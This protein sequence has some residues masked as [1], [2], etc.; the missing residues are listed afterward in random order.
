VLLVSAAVSPLIW[1]GYIGH[2]NGLMFLVAGAL[3]CPLSVV[4][5]VLDD[6]L[7]D[8][9]AFYMTGWPYFRTLGELGAAA[10]LNIYLIRICQSGGNSERR[11][12]NGVCRS[13]ITQ[14]RWRV[15]LG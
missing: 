4:L 14:R 10:L 15:S 9:N 5:L 7:S 1:D 13:A 11:E 12:H 6:L 8:V 2:G 3:T